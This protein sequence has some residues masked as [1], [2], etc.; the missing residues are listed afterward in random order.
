L[1]KVEPDF[2]DLRGTS[3][4]QKLLLRRSS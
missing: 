2:A 1:A 3:A 4:F